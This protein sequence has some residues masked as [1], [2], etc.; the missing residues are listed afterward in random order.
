MC[1]WQRLTDTI[2][3]IRTHVKE[4]QTLFQALRIPKWVFL[5]IIVHMGH[6]ICDRLRDYWTRTQQFFAPFYLNTMTWDHFL[7]IL[8]HYL[9]FTD[10]DKVIDNNDR[11]WKIKEFFD[12]LNGVYSKFY[13]PSEHLATDQVTVL[14]KVKVAFKQYIPKIHKHLGIKIYK[15]CDISWLHIWHGCVVSEGQKMGHKTWQWSMLLWNKWEG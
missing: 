5:A 2:P 1:W 4:H 13:N 8:L 15:L 6:N 10:N 9:H 3:N 12:I 14:F 11:L 7:H